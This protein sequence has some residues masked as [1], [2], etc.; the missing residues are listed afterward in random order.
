[1]SR[2][3]RRIGARRGRP[4]PTVQCPLSERQRRRRLK[5]IRTLL[6][7][8]PDDEVAVYKDE[9]DIHLNPKVGLDWML[10][11]EQKRLVTPG[12]NEKAYIAG[13]LDARD[14]TV[15]WVGDGVKNS[16]LFIAMMRRLDE[17][18]RDARMHPRHPRQLRNTQEP[19]DDRSAARTSSHSASL[20]AALL[21][22]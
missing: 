7:E 15:L 1:M 5:K 6:D 2:I 20:P 11:G 8:L 4:K 12:K 13:T 10:S 18:Y 19:R 16:S 21:P 3:L 9:V 17:H 22:R 14:G